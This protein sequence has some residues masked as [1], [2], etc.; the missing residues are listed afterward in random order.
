MPGQ[1]HVDEGT[2]RQS[3]LATVQLGGPIIVGPVVPEPTT[4]LLLALG[5]AGALRARHRARA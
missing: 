4:G 3:Q 1:R 2:Q 5:L